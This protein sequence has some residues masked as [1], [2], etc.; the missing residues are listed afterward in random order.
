MLFN[1]VPMGNH[2]SFGFWSRV[3]PN[4]VDINGLRVEHSN[5]Y[6]F[7]G[8]RFI[9]D[10]HSFGI[11][12]DGI[13]RVSNTEYPIF[14]LYAISE[15]SFA[16]NFCPHEHPYQWYDAD[17]VI[18]WNPLTMEKEVTR[19][20]QVYVPPVTGE[21]ITCEEAA[22]EILKIL[23]TSMHEIAA[24]PKRFDLYASGGLDTAVL[25]AIVMADELPINIIYRSQG[26]HHIGEKHYN[27]AGPQHRWMMGSPNHT[28]FKMLPVWSDNI[29]TGH[30][31]GMEIVRWPD[32]MRGLFT[33]HGFDW[34]YAHQ[35]NFDSYLGKFHDNKAHQ[36]SHSG[37]YPG[38]T[39]TEDSTIEDARWY[40]D[41]VLM[42]TSEVWDVDGKDIRTPFRNRDI[43]WWVTALGGNS[44]VEQGFHSEVHK[45]IIKMTYPKLLKTVDKIKD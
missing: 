45:Q 42:H 24:S 35:R 21:K 16:S 17:A 28:D 12:D 13:F 8:K 22:T 9:S 14:Q 3:F 10:K 40:A 2:G 44:L 15:Q 39:V 38:M 31:G 34:D 23:R 20:E 32:A 1:I 33:L 26:E 11:E 36:A 7:D 25:Q 27:Q 4:S 30:Y 5:D 37:K 6:R 19:R 29:I 18:S 43:H 41:N